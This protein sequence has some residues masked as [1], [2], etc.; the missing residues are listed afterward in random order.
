MDPTTGMPA[1]QVALAYVDSVEGS[2]NGEVLD[3]RALAK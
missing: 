3:T 2:R 1:K